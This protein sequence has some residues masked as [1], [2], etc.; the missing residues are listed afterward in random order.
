MGDI[1][2]TKDLELTK[3]TIPELWE[4]YL[5]QE[6][7]SIPYINV[8]DFVLIN[9]KEVLLDG[10]HECKSQAVLNN[11][12]QLVKI[13][14]VNRLDEDLWQYIFKDTAITEAALFDSDIE[15]VLKFKEAN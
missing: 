1:E 6:D 8:G 12:H 13:I 3:H 7:K 2:M 10:D 5:A 14:K 11:A 15:I 4:S 9:S